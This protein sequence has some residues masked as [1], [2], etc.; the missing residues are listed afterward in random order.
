MET[1]FI[2]QSQNE[3]SE[4]LSKL[5]DQ[6]DETIPTFEILLELITEFKI[7]ACRYHTCYQHMLGQTIDM[8][9][10]DIKEMFE[11][12]NEKPKLEDKNEE[13]SFNDK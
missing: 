8:L 13:D 6:Y 12:I 1:E 3:F 7:L 4:K 9:T 10:H 11:Y 2:E 5:I